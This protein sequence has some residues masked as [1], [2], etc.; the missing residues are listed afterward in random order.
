MKRYQ[1]DRGAISVLKGTTNVHV[2][3]S[4]EWQQMCVCMHMHLHAL[5][6]FNPNQDTDGC[7]HLCLCEDYIWVLLTAVLC[8]RQHVQSDLRVYGCTSMSVCVS[9]GYMLSFFTD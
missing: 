3:V 6:T 7:L 9:L 1:V 5:V 8:L 2:L 4:G